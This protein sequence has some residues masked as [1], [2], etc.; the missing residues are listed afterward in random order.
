MKHLFIFI[1]LVRYLWWDKGV[2]HTFTWPSSVLWTIGLKCCMSK[3]FM[4]SGN[5]L[6]A[7]QCAAMSATRSWA[8]A[9]FEGPLFFLVFFG[10]G[11][12]LGPAVVL[13]VLVLDGIWFGGGMVG[14]NAEGVVED[15]IQCF[16]GAIVGDAEVGGKKKR[17]ARPY[18]P[19]HE[20]SWSRTHGWKSKSKQVSDCSPS[21]VFANQGLW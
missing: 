3:P 4:I 9:P 14:G 19:F 1:C 8:L 20:A 12:A 17:T 13:G 11:A 15:L 16:Q 10:D 5:A 18:Q 6:D 21:I 7:P 2:T